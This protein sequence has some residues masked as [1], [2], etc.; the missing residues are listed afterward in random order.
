M[1]VDPNGAVV[2][3]DVIKGLSLGLTEAAT[4]AVRKWEFSPATEGGTPIEGELTVAV[5]FRLS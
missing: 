2:A 1:T 4:K 5:S 3:V